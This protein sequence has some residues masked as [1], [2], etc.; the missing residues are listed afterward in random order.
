MTDIFIYVSLFAI[1]F[2]AATIL[3]LQS[4]LAVAALLLD[5]SHA[6]RTVILVASLGNILGSTVNWLLGRSLE[7]FKDRRWFP[8]NAKNLGRAEAWYHKYGRASLLLSWMPVIGD[9]LTVMA[10]VFREPLWS[11]LLFVGIAKVGR[12]LLLTAVTL[13]WTA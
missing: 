2:G 10:G 5:G 3:P 12:Y 1:A 11:F 4:E 9:A 6:W 7:K 13:Q 8:V